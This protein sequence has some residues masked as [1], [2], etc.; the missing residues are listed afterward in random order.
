[1]LD[2][3]TFLPVTGMPMRKM[4]CMSRLFALAEPVPLTVPIL[5]A[6]SLTGIRHDQ[7]ELSHV[8]G[9]GRTAFGAE[10]AMQA[11]VFVLYHQ[12]LRLRQRPRT[13]DGLLGVRRRR[14]QVG[15]QIELRRRVGRD[16]QTV[17][18]A[19]VDA[20]VALDAQA[21]REVR[22]YVTVQT[23]LDFPRRLFRGE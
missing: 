7:F 10:P 23:A 5:K 11:D 14:G 15:A 19:D 18:R 8:P 9:R 16:G 22:L 2:G 3:K 20:G 4:A 12:P 6:K 1:M 21:V 13:E 17:H